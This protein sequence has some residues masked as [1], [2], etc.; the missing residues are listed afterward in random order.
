MIDCIVCYYTVNLGRSVCFSFVLLTLIML[1]RRLPLF[2]GCFQRM[3]LWSTVLW[4]PFIGGLKLFYETK[5]GIRGFLWWANFNYI[6]PGVGRIYFLVMALYGGFLCYRRSRLL[7]SVRSLEHWRE[8]IFIC[9]KAVTPFAA[10]LFSPKIVVPR[11]M[12]EGCDAKE[13]EM[14]LLHERTHI[15]LGHLWQLFLWDILRVLFWPNFCMT[16]CMRTLKAD[17]EEVCDRVTIQRGKGSPCEY[18][19]LLLKC[20]ELLEIRGA[21]WEPIESVSFAGDRERNR[22]DELR[23]RIV[24]IADFRQYRRANVLGILL[25]ELL[26]LAGGFWGIHSNSYAR[27]TELKDIMVLDDTGF[28][29]ILKDSFELRQAIS[30][31]EYKVTIETRALED[32]LEESGS[33]TRGIYI[34]FGGFMKQPGVGGG[35]NMVYADLAELSG[36]KVEIAYDR[37]RDVRTWVLMNM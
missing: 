19:L 12:L 30:F 24:K 27:Y 14:I 37:R 13:L 1:L 18:G 7:R 8:N 26:V 17:L 35:G 23:Q 32:I 3:V 4:L 21:K 34:V 9:E 33:P 31:D 6:H 15:R 20:T 10:G 11:M 36:E 22:Y 5:F 28:R 16:L 25:V 2:R 29:V